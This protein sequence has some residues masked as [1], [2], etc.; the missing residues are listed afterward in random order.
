[1]R[2]YEAGFYSS[3]LGQLIL[4]LAVVLSLV[5]FAL[6]RRFAARGLTLEVKEMAQ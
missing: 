4:A 5:A 6:A 2:S 1:M 3:L